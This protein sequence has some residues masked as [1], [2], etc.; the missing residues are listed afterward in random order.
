[1]VKPYSIF[2]RS[3]GF[4]YVQFRMPDGSRSTN[5]STGT[6]NRTEA[7]RIAMEWVVNGN[8]PT[9]VNSASNQTTSTNIT[10]MD[11]F[12]K[13]KSFD[14]TTEEIESIIS[15][16][17]GRKYISSAVICNTV[18]DKPIEPYILSFWN[19]ETS[20]YVKEKLLK[21]QS[22][23]RSYCETMKSRINIYWLPK[24]KGKTIGSITR[25]DIMS[26][27][28]DKEIT[29]LAPKTINSIVSAMTI[30]MKWAFYNELTENNCFDGIIKCSQ[31]SKQ[32]EI[33]TLEQAYALFSIRWDNDAA[34]LANEL[35]FYTGMR[36]GEIAA[37]QLQDIGK[38]RIY[39]RHSWSKYD[40]LKETKTNETRQIKIPPKLRDE[41]LSQA[42]LNPY[43]EGQ[44]AFIFFGLVPKQPTDPK[45]WLKYLRRELKRIGHTEPEKICFHSWRHL[46][47]SRVRDLIGDNRVI[48]QGSG[49][50]TETML[51]LY[52]SHLVVENALNQL[53]KAQE[54]LFLPAIEN[55][56]V[57]VD[58]EIEDIPDSQ[59]WINTDI[60]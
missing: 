39:I 9:R 4:Y 1:M 59:K 53:E 54:K 24:I 41:L 20:P 57:D 10:K 6:K 48:M 33:L 43:N 14:F 30:P 5:K 2:K 22:I 46:W 52:S 50:K 8:I 31:K 11:F 47:C 60:A 18:E 36:A 28:Q 27:F 16:L 19:Y 23:H 25:K 44:Q 29:D 42:Y 32:R 58:Y 38:D 3:S 13:L 26:I 35:A 21:G 51:N 49:H 12:T 15:I 7:E 37:L 56:T 40:G 45:N 34:K 55:D 17:K